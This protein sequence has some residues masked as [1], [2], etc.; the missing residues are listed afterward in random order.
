LQIYKNQ[1]LIFFKGINFIR[2][3]QKKV[4]IR[5]GFNVGHYLQIASIALIFTGRE[6]ACK[7]YLAG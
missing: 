6:A 7:Q 1:S 3:K 4:I 5:V 2:T